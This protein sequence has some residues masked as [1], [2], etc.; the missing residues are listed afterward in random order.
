MET[1]ETDLTIPIPLFNTGW[2]AGLARGAKI[3]VLSAQ[4]AGA[5]P[6]VAVRVQRNVEVDTHEHPAALYVQVVDALHSTLSV[7]ST[8]RLE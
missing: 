3:K 7:R 2:Q 8:T 5:R 4:L 1:Q 6:G